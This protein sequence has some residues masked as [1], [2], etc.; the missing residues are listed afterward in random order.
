MAV[1]SACSYE[2]SSGSAACLRSFSIQRGTSTPSHRRKSSVF[3]DPQTENVKTNGAAHA[4]RPT[5]VVIVGDEVL[6]RVEVVDD[7]GHEEPA[8]GLL[9][10]QQAQV[11][12]LAA[13]V[14]LGYRDAAQRQRRVELRGAAPARRPATSE[15]V[16]ALDGAPTRTVITRAGSCADSQARS[17]SGAYLPT[18]R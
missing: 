10:G 18:A 17:S 3:I 8:A 16:A 11:L 1:V 12:V 5:L 13:A 7:L 6:R 2:A 14:A 4:A 9:L 15:P